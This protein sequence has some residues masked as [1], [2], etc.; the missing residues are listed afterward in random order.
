MFYSDD[1][2]LSL[3]S[4]SHHSNKMNTLYN[5]M[6]NLVD[7]EIDRQLKSDDFESLL[8]DYTSSIS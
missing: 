6:V 1:C 3:V 4:I 2:K 8:V 5:F 7:R